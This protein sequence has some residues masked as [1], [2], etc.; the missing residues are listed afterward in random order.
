[1]EDPK[2]R[3]ELLALRESQNERREEIIERDIQNLIRIIRER[4]RGSNFK[5]DM[6]KKQKNRKSRICLT[7]QKRL[8]LTNIL[9]KWGND[10]VQKWI[11]FRIGCDII[12]D[13]RIDYGDDFY[14]KI[15]E[16]RNRMLIIK[17]RLYFCWE[18]IEN[19]NKSIFPKMKISKPRWIKYDPRSMS[20]QSPYERLM[21]IQKE[22]AENRNHLFED[23]VNNFTVIVKKLSR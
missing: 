1:M 14:L 18:P 3:Q 10:K 12:G 15:V 19:A 13:L 20:E 22:Q 2:L 7:P 11:L 6:I 5:K 9:S 4:I 17:H 23:R 21:R 8:S 16:K